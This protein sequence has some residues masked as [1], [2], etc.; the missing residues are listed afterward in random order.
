M[1]GGL[2]RPP[3]AANLEENFYRKLHI[4]RLTRAE[5]RSAIEVADRVTDY[6]VGAHRGSTRCEVLPIEHIEHLGAELHSCALLHGEVLEY[7]QVNVGESW[8]RKHIAAQVA[9]RI[10][11]AGATGGSRNAESVGVDPRLTARRNA[12]SVTHPRERIADDV[13]SR[14][15]R[16]RIEVERL[17]TMERH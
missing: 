17:S 7:R 15:L 1:C 13:Q 8:A 16:S 9:S 3:W 6:A 12:E 14:S 10:C 2:P 5:P 4:E 11:S